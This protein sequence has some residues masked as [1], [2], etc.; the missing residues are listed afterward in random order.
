MSLMIML[1]I[2]NV[3]NDYVVYLNFS[4]IGLNFDF[5]AYNLTGFVAYGVFNVGLFWVKDVQVNTV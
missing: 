5:L 1:Y 3:I 2:Q 4:V